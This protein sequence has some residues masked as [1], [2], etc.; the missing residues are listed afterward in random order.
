MRFALAL[1]LLSLVCTCG[2]AQNVEGF[3]SSI[4]ER[5]ASKD[6]LR[7]QGNAGATFG[8]NYFNDDGSGARRRVQPFNWR[9]NAGLTFDILGIKAPFNAAFSNRNSLYNLP[10]YSFYGISPSYKWITLHAG[11]RSISFSPYSL[12][13]VNF[14]GGGIELRPGKFYLAAMR[15]RLR[16]ARLQ[17]AGSIQD[18]EGAYRRI[19]S[20]LKLGFDNQKGSSLTTSIFSSAD[21]LTIDPNQLDTS[22]LARPERNMVLTVSAS[23]ELSEF[24]SVQGEWGRSVLTRDD[25]SPLLNDPS[26]Q[27][28]LFG[29]FDPKTTTTAA[30]A[31]K[32][33]ITLS[34]KFGKLNLQYER[35][36]PEYR[37]HGALF[38][39]NDLENFTGGISAPLF[40]NKLMLSANLGLQRNDLDNSSASNNNRFIGSLNLSYTVSDR[41]NTS[42][43]F[44]NFTTT[45]RYKAIAVNNLLVDSIVLAQTQQSFD[46]S[47]SVLLDAKGE[48]ALVFSGSYQR[49]ALIRDDVLDTDQVSRFAMLL[50]SYARQVEGAKGSFS[51]SL[52][53]HRNATVDLTIS[54]IGPNVGYNRKIF[55]DKGNLSFQAGY[56]LALT[57]FGANF[58]GIEDATTGV[59]QSSLGSSYKLGKKQTFNLSVTFVNSG[60]TEA[61]PGF[62][63]LQINGGWGIG[64]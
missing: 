49:A 18:I 1:L 6:Y 47:A 27:V 37:T 2:R 43:G 16:R 8:Y 24:L 40:D 5:L 32:T 44:S 21:E 61:R 52:L 56:Q 62:T 10:S 35:V 38:F 55:T 12:S 39:Q 33:R 60:G 17:D 14:R 42:F 3:F 20:G 45:N 48:N 19:G 41:I 58:P 57:S 50:V 23:H 46:G 11:D 34:P 22:L 54:T 4:S 28:T 26:G 59:F 7:M 63:D 13:G 25:R 15:G 31:F 36:A 29:L 51:G 53:F 30:N 9:L 64:F